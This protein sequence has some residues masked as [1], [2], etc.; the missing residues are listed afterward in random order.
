MNDINIGNVIARERR[1]IGVTQEDLAAH[2]GVTKAAVSK[3]E[4]GQSLPDTTL[5]PRIAAYFDLTLDELFDYRPQVSKERVRELYAELLE[6]FG[7]D[8]DAAYERMEDLA[9]SYYACWDLLVHIGMLYVLRATADEERREE[10]VRR[11]GALF[12]RVEACAEDLELIRNVKIMRAS[13][14]TVSGDVEAA[15]R[16]LEAL[17]PDR[18]APIDDMLAGLYDMKGD[19]ESCLRLLQES[20]YCG[21]TGAFNSIVFQLSIEEDRQRVEALVRAGEAMVRGFAFE[22]D[23]PMMVGMFWGDAFAAFLR[24]GDEDRASACLERFVLLLEGMDEDAMPKPPSDVLFDRLSGARGQDP[25]TSRMAQAL[26]GKAG[27]KGQVRDGVLRDGVLDGLERS[28]R[29]SGLLAR[30]KAL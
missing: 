14:M 2:M 18:C 21:S 28:P 17:K 20:L 13:M 29:F 25:S 24:A 9:A 11:A 30:L 8:P 12:D 7:D 19:R 15:I 3:W 26:F 27:L 22:D 5:L 10:N 6:Q 16:L 1:A 4:L 23:N